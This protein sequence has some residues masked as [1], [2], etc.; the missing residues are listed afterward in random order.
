MRLAW[1]ASRLRSMDAGE[2]VWRARNMLLQH[3]WRGRRGAAWPTPRTT[4]PRWGS[5][6]VPG[7]LAPNPEEIRALQS[8]AGRVLTGSWRAL[9]AP[10]DLTGTDPDWFRDPR[11]SRRA[12][13]DSYAFDVP[14]RDEARVGNVK[15]LWEVSRLQ[16]V[17]LLAAGRLL[18]ALSFGNRFLAAETVERMLGVPVLIALPH[19]PAL[20]RR[21][22]IP[23]IQGDDTSGRLTAQ[24]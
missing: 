3:T 19:V 1:Y 10:V 23:L 9:S 12:S 4:T 22:Q 14:Y 6:L 18:L 5:R 16:H 13:P 11:T 2:V 15:H 7:Q 17:T 24:P 8:L 21:R 20:H